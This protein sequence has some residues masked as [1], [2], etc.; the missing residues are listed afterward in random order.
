MTL[1]PL[2][3]IVTYY[4]E[5]ASRSLASFSRLACFEQAPRLLEA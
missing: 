1:E 2:E 3:N 5:E 4:E